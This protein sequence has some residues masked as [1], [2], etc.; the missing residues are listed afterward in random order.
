LKELSIG[1][2]IGPGTFMTGT[3]LSGRGCSVA[4]MDSAFARNEARAWFLT[5]QSV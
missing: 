5:V 4:W 1:V 3:D 2:R